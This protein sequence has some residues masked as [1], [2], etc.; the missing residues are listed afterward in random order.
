MEALV[1]I[2]SEAAEAGQCRTVDEQEVTVI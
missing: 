1:M 2:I